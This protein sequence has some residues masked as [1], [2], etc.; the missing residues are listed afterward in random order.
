MVTGIIDCLGHENDFRNK[1][2]TALIDER[3]GWWGRSSVFR[4]DKWARA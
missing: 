2:D 1:P 4:F 3:N